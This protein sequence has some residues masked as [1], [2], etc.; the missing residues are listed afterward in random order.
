[1]F[2]IFSSFVAKFFFN[3]A[4]NLVIIILNVTFATEFK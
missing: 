3:Y 4:I 1:M 2:L